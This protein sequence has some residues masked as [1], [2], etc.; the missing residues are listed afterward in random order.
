MN[1]KHITNAMK[2]RNRCTKQAYF[3]IYKEAKTLIASIE[4]EPLRQILE[5]ADKQID[6]RGTKIHELIS[7]ILYISLECNLIGEYIINYGWDMNI[8]SSN[9]Y[10]LTSAFLRFVYKFTMSDATSINIEDSISTEYVIT[11][12]SE[13]FEYMIDC[14]KH[15]TLSTVKYKPLISKRKQL[16]AVA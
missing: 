5:R 2:E 14:N 12:C 1:T 15:H 4:S 16:K 9:Y 6:E 7:C 3:R 8:K 10:D 11:D 13:L